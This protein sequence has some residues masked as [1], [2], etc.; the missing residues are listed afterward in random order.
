MRVLFLDFDGV[1][2]S[3]SWF[4][5]NIQ[6]IQEST[7]LLQR[8]EQEL[9]PELVRRVSDLVVETNARVVISSTW[10]RLHSL[11]AINTMLVAAGWQAPP[12]IST[13]PRTQE[14]FRGHEVNLWLAEHPEVTRHVILDDDSD[15]LPE[16]PLVRTDH[17]D[18]IQPT[19]VQRAREILLGLA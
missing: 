11:E 4:E 17:R 1:L 18:G 10:R 9:D 12:A 16:Q 8:G 3:R 7:T 5:R 15:F 14:G 2:N 13:T 6:A 19:G